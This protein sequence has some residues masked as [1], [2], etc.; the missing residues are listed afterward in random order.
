MGVVGGRD[1]GRKRGG[2]GLRAIIRLIWGY[3][4]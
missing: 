4:D 3:V 2:R 1:K